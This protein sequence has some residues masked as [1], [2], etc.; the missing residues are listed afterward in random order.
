MNEKNISSEGKKFTGERHKKIQ[1]FVECHY[2]SYPHAYNIGWMLRLAK[3]ADF[4]Y[5]ISKV[6][7]LC[8]NQPDI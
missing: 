6:T 8:M 3:K 4:A 1:T 5:N 7:S 2:L